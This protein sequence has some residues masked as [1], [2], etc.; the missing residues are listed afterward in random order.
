MKITREFAIGSKH[1]YDKCN[2]LFRVDNGNCE[3][4]TEIRLSDNV[5]AEHQKEKFLF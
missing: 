2:A 3:T 1:C 5:S 4:S